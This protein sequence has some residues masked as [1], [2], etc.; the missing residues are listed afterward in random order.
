MTK[1]QIPNTNSKVYG[2]GI[3]LAGL[4]DWLVFTYELESS[5]WVRCIACQALRE[6]ALWG[7]FFMFAICSFYGFRWLMRGIRNDILDSLGHPVAARSWFIVG[8]VLMQVPLA[9]F[10]VF[11]WRQGLFR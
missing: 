2:A 10:A 3:S 6:Q 7:G 1:I 11:A 8:G 4:G 9:I 5:E